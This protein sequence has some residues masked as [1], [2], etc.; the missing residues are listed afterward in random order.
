MIYPESD[1]DIKARLLWVDGA[2]LNLTAM[3]RTDFVRD[4]PHFYDAIFPINHDYIFFIAMMRA[5]ATFFSLKQPLQLYRRHA[6][7]ATND[8]SRQDE[9][10]T[11]VRTTLLPMFFP[12]LTGSEG[13]IMLKLLRRDFSRDPARGLQFH[14]G[15]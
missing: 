9:E 3:F 2:L 12:E 5:G 13:K 11:A 7:N 14:R 10:K 15:G 8:E 6:E 4:H 1:G